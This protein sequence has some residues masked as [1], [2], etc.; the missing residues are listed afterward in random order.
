MIIFWT[1]PVV[2]LWTEWFTVLCLMGR[3]NYLWR[4][5]C[6]FL[7]NGRV[8]CILFNWPIDFFGKKTLMF[9]CDRKGSLYLGRW[10]C[11]S[12]ELLAK[13]IV[14]FSCERI[15]SLYLL[16]LAWLP[17]VLLASGKRN[18][19]WYI[20]GRNVEVRMCIIR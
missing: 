16:W 4:K 19:V 18:L 13:K 12:F 10:T 1:N 7:V 15:G 9:C 6:W 20:V 5:P 14:L 11:M 2:L 17:L 3:S 8:H